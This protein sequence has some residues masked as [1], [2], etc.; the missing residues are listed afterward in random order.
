TVLSSF[1]TPKTAAVPKGWS[2]AVRSSVPDGNL[3]PVF[4]AYVEGEKGGTLAYPLPPSWS[5]VQVGIFDKQRK[6]VYGNVI[7][8]ELVNGGYAY[9]LVF[10]NES[11]DRTRISYTVERLAAPRDIEIA[12]IDPSDRTV[13]PG[14]SQLTLDVAG[15]SREYRLLAIGTPQ[16]ID[17]FGRAIRRGEFGITRI[18]P[19]P[20]RATLR[21]QYVVPYGGLESIRCDIIDQLGRVVW[22]EKPGRAIH[23][24]KNEILWTAR[25][26]KPLAAGAYF[27]RLVG[28]DGKGKKTAEKLARIMYLP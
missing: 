28:F 1:S 17:G 9:E 21:I 27:V 18:S 15:Y 4:C 6:G 24:G 26:G 13:A 20:F 5:K 12:L 11:P 3:S 10:E 16:Y 2:V 19:N 7:V 22:S 14:E 25:D 23:P 8:R